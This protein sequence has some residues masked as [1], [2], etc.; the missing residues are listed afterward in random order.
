MKEN[1]KS[2]LF[3]KWVLMGGLIAGLVV[4][5]GLVFTLMPGKPDPNVI[6]K[7]YVEGNTDKLGEDLAGF[8]V[9]DNW[10]LKELGGEY[11]EGRINNVIQWSYSPARLVRSDR[12]EV[13]ATAAA[14]F[15]LDYASL[16]RTYFVEVSLPFLLKVDVDNGIVTSEPQYSKARLEHDIPNV[17]DLPDIGEVKEQAEEVKEKAGDLLQKIKN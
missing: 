10:L 16:S 7:E 9:G 11:I 14:V 1:K 15:N 17:P 12:Y 6:A 4:I 13:T 8:V 3:N 5:A 2:P